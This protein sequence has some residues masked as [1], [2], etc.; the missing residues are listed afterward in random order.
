MQVV[1]QLAKNL[2]EVRLL[3]VPL[4]SDYLHT[5]YFPDKATQE[6]YFKEKTLHT[7]NNCTYQRAEGYIRFDKPIDDII[8]S[9]YVMYRNTAFSNKWYYAFIT[10]MEYKDDSVTLVYIERDVIQTWC[11]D[12]RLRH[13]FIEREHVSNDD[14]GV[15]TVPENLELGDY[16]INNSVDGGGFDKKG[17]VLGCTVDLSKMEYVPD[18]WLPNLIAGSP[19]CEPISGSLYG[20]VFSGVHYY[21]FPL[22]ED[23]TT[24]LT[25]YSELELVIKCLGSMGQSDCIVSIFMVPERLI[26]YTQTGAVILQND[27]AVIVKL[28]SIK[29]SFNCVFLN[30]DS[31]NLS[32]G[33]Y[34]PTSLNGYIPRNN[35]MFTFPYCYV[36][37]SNNA[38]GSAI[39]KYELF[40][41]GGDLC[42]FQING[43][44]TPGFSARLVPLHYNGSDK[45]DEEGLN[46][47]KLPICAWNSDVYTN[48]LTQ[49]SVN[50]GISV[51]S[52]VMA[53]GG[54]V[55]LLATG[56]GATA[57][58]GAIAGG[59]MGIASTM[60][61][62]YQHSLQPP[63][64]EGNINNGDVIY[65]TD[66][67]CFT[68]YQMSVKKEYAKMIDNYFTMFGYKVN[69][70]H[71]PLQNHR[72]A[73][74]FTK[75]IDVN[76]D[77]AIPQEDMRKVKECY[78][79][80]I[81]FWRHTVD[82]GN[83]SQDNGI[84]EGVTT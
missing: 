69:H 21:Y 49:N 55:A 22:Y 73:F 82:I 27:P 54:G 61:E 7:M 39:Y 64:A 79:K 34:K 10:K 41:N 20:G 12:Y 84:I 60:A 50:M 44:V 67:L 71:R 26:S 1:F 70:L 77:G 81:T 8:K 4:E 32:G 31:S 43:V 48:W 30:W 9:N 23:E 17:I 53:I 25:G 78:N 18:G 52:S 11:F 66:R 62:K 24:G 72:E 35:K 33:V 37:M 13:S 6:S 2:T 3:S 46:A 68:A 15:N 47:G 57:G 29:E 45:N 38:G 16:I 19:K 59:V 83:Y 58:A 14:I 28:R 63:Q 51:A 65:A 74:W 42:T 36:N 76:I 40:D 56:A 80:G 75:T 5:I